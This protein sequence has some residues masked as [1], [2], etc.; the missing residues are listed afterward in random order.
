MRTNNAKVKN[1]L[2][3]IYFVLIVLV[4]LMATIFSIFSH[5]T[6]SPILVFMALLIG[7]LALFLMVHTVSRY[8][9]Y[10]SDGKKVLLFNKG[11]L[12]SNYFNYREHKLE[13]HRS[14]LKA[15]R[16]KNYIVY[17][18]LTLYVKNSKGHTKKETFNLT[19][20]SKRKRRYIR[21]SLSKMIKNN[22]QPTN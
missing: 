22:T 6:S 19:L 18:S 11:L 4:I 13:F 7:F 15:F 21:Q 9:E 10:D 2:V 12:L 14:R 3:S 8:F 1:T 20:V 17:K 5:L 16:F